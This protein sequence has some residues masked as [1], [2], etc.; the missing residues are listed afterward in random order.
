MGNR[1]AGDP[2]RTEVED[3]LARHHGL[4]YR[5][6]YR[7]CRNPADAEDIAQEVFLRIARSPG[8]L[9]GIRDERAWLAQA[10]WNRA[11]T[12]LRS[13][14]RRR[15]R[16]RAWASERLRETREGN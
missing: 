4:V 15:E 11:V 14:S 6:A 13:E 5:L 12:F 1:P 8:C 3:L 2:R 7:V 16:E 10:T 9:E